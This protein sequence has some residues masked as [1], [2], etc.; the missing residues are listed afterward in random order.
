MVPSLVRL[1]LVRIQDD[2]GE[3][4][5]TTS[6]LL[7]KRDCSQKSAPVTL[8][9]C[10]E[11]ETHHVVDVL[12][13]WSRLGIAGPVA[14]LSV[15]RA[16]EIGA[17]SIVYFGFSFAFLMSGLYHFHDVYVSKGGHVRRS[18]R[19]QQ[20]IC[21]KTLCLLDVTGVASSGIVLS[22]ALLL[23]ASKQRVLDWKTW[24]DG[25]LVLLVAIAV[26][27]HV[28]LAGNGELYG[29]DNTNAIA[30]ATVVLATSLS[31]IPPYVAARS[32]LYEAGVDVAVLVLIVS[33]LGLV[34]VGGVVEVISSRTCQGVLRGV[35][36]LT[37]HA[38]A[39]GTAGCVLAACEL[40]HVAVRSVN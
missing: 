3:Q 5:S 32:I 13:V 11:E 25:P 38:C 28:M 17:L 1:P 30:Y 19:Y 23:V 22:I 16:F 37:W 33:G 34:A 24:S 2:G 20:S 4:T 39:I 12:V 21:T 18:Q 26:V 35:A 9:T 29:E 7:S 14:I 36:H 10:R 15:V 40:M 27:A 8:E 31:W 6:P